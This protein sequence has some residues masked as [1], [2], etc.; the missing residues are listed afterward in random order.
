MGKK[1]LIVAHGNTLR[2]IIKYLDNISD[3][4]FL[5]INIPTGIPIVYELDKKLNPINRYFLGDLEE[6]ENKIS[7]VKNQISFGD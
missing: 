7:K 4:K 3:E 5:E 2:A 6:I 1:V